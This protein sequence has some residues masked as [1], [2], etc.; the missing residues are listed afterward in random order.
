MSFFNMISQLGVVN[1]I[2]MNWHYFGW[3][4]VLHFYI[5]ASRNLIIDN[6][7]GSI[8][9]MNKPTRGCIKL[10]LKRIGICDAKRERAIWNNSGTIKVTDHIDLGSGTRLVNSGNMIFGSNFMLKGNSKIICHR[11]ITFGDDVLIS[12]DVLLMDTDHH[13]IYKLDETSQ[14]I[15]T[16]KAISIGNHVWIGCNTII[17][18]GT[19]LPDNVVLAAGCVASG[20]YTERNCII[21]GKKYLKENINWEY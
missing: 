12:W 14:Q 7:G 5:I 13:K 16:P 1:T 11:E 2:R 9:M 8:T 4:G 15:N 17:L 20:K 6:C 3:R 10:G 21:V 19:S 18:K